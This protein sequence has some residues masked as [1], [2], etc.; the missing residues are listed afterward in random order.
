[1]DDVNN[2]KWSVK[3]CTGDLVKKDMNL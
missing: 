3:L 1:M 2:G